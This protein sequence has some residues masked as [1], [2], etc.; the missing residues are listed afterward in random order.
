MKEV[1]NMIELDKIY[2]AD[3]YQ[4]IKEISNKSIDCIYVD[5]P[6]LYTTGGTSKTE[7]GARRKKLNNQLHN[8]NLKLSANLGSNKYKE[9]K[10]DKDHTKKRL[11]VASMD[12]GIDYTILD[13]FCRVMKKI[14]IFIWCS[15]A[16]ILDLL[17]YFYEKKKCNFELL[18]WAKTNSMPTNQ[19]FLSNLEYCLYF[20][21]TGVK[22][23][24]EHYLKSKW[25]ISGTN[26]KDKSKWLHPTIKPLEFVT[27]HILLAT[28]PN[29]VVLDCFAG[30]GTTGVACKNTG[31]HFILIE[32]NKDFYNISNDRVNNKIDC[33]GQFSMFTL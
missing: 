19:C 22:I 15:K 11:D 18:V 21:E 4:K 9:I 23:N 5:I 33:T 29:D 3:C 1:K 20:R 12:T 13:D 28:K 6:Y 26:K 10:I 27:N 7:M 17:K 8:F 16:Q 2:N 25:F 32:K 24:N 31:R 30:S 14:N